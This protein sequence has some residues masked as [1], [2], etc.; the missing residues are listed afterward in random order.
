MKPLRPSWVR[1]W[2]GGDAVKY[3]APT[4]RWEDIEERRRFEQRRRC[5]RGALTFADARWI[6][7]NISAEGARF[8]LIQRATRVLAPCNA[9]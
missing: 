4:M 2:V 3:V 5:H 9:M 6:C 8:S 1:S 7:R